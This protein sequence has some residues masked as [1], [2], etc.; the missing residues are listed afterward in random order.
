[1][2]DEHN[3]ELAGEQQPDRDNVYGNEH[4]IKHIVNYG[5]CGM[6]KHGIN[7]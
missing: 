7:A 1:M 3:S 5:E 4:N 6:D 2:G